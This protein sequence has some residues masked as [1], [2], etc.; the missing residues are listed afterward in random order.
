MAFPLAALASVAGSV[1]GSGGAGVSQALGAASSAISQ[2]TGLLHDMKAKLVGI[3]DTAT[4][5]VRG[6]NPALVAHL[7]R[8]F[9]ALNNV[10]G[11]SLQ[12]IVK[13]GADV[14]RFLAGSLVPTVKLFGNMISSVAGGLGDWLKG[15]IANFSA[16]M[17]PLIPL[18]AGIA[19][20]VT[21]L[22]R[23]F[24]TLTEGIRPLWSLVGDLIS[25]MEPLGKIADG[26]MDV[27]VD[28][29]DAMRVYYE[30]IAESGKA[31]IDML[32]GLFGAD[33]NIKDIM[34]Q[35][36]DAI[37]TVIKFLITMAAVLMKWLGSQA[38]LDAILRGLQ[39]KALQAA[40]PD[41]FLM[42][43]NPAFKGLADVARDLTQA[44]FVA[45]AQGQGGAKKDAAAWL[46]EMI[47]MIQGMKDDAKS[48]LIP[49]VERI[50]TGVE[51]AIKAVEGIVG[52]IPQAPALPSTDDIKQEAKDWRDA[53]MRQANLLRQ[54]FGFP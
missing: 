35:F 33:V 44:A 30:L 27:F 16:F 11:A 3:L 4:H 13:V 50:A 12:P 32:A 19:D 7:N 39:P 31:L 23:G 1:G 46:Q 29:A 54:K 14:V 22:M 38:G 6:F 18:A 42:P 20:R 40:N 8:Q 53:A 26:L 43:Q 2:V 25:R 17:Q 41:G 45:T 21:K 24:G 9:E 52:K 37:Q 49:Q 15:G 5:F 48:G 34:G 47:P 28:M 51:N 10:I 36:R